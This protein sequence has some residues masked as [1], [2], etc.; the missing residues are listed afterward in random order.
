METTL[1]TLL[2]TV[3]SLPVLYMLQ[4]KIFSIGKLH[5]K[6]LHSKSSLSKS[7]IDPT[8]TIEPL[9]DFDINTTPPIRYRPY[10][11]QGHVTMGI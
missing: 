9:W 5:P 8:A 11:V 10:E 2:T 1:Y 3:I 4:G 6:F 7:S